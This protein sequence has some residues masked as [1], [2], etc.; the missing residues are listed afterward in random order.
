MVHRIVVEDQSLRWY[1]RPP[2]I[3]D[4]SIEFVR[5][6]F[7]LPE[8]WDPL[9]LVAQF[10]QADTYNMLLDGDTCF[11]P[12]E[13]TPGLCKL[14]LFGYAE[15]KPLRATSIPLVFQIEESGFVS[16]A[17]TPIPPTPDLYAQLIDHFA[18]TAGSGGKSNVFIAEYGVTS[19]EEIQTAID[20]GKQ[21]Y[22][23]FSSIYYPYSNAMPDMWF[24]FSVCYRA[25]LQ[26]VTCT[27]DGKWTFNTIGAVSESDVKAEIK[28][29]YL[30][31]AIPTVK[32]VMD[33]A[34]PKGDYLLTPIGAIPGQMLAVKTVD[35]NGKPTEWETVT[36]KSIDESQ[37]VKASTLFESSGSD[38]TVLLPEVSI[39]IPDEGFVIREKILEISA[40]EE[41][42]ITWNGVEYD[43]VVQHLQEGDLSMLYF[44]GNVDALMG[45][46]D[47][48]EPFII[49]YVPDEYAETVGYS[50]GIISLYGESDVTLSVS[51]K[52]SK[53]IKAKYLPDIPGSGGNLELD[54]TLTQ[55]GKAADAKAVGDAISELS[56]GN[57]D[58]T[59]IVKSV[60]GVEPD[61]NGNV[62]L[63]GNCL[64]VD[65]D[66][67]T[68]KASHSYSEIMTAINNGSIV[69]M[70]YGGG[71]CRLDSYDD[72]AVYF[73]DL[74]P[75]DGVWQFTLKVLDDKSVI[76]NQQH[77]NYGKVKMVNGRMPDSDGDVKL[78]TGAT[79]WD[80]LPGRPF[81]VART[82]YNENTLKVE[83]DGYGYFGIGVT[84]FSPVTIDETYTFIVNGAKY[85]AVALDDVS[86]GSINFDFN[87]YEG[88][89]LNSVYVE[90]Y[91]GEYGEIVSG[92]NAGIVFRESGTYTVKVIKEGPTTLDEKFI[93]DTIARVKDIP[94]DFVT[95]WNDLTDK[96][97]GENAEVILEETPITFTEDNSYE[98]QFPY[99]KPFVH[100]EI[101]AIVVNGVTYELPGLI[102]HDMGDFM[103]D[104]WESD[105][106]VRVWQN[107]IYD[108]VNLVGFEYTAISVDWGTSETMTV[109]VYK[110]G[111]VKTLDE[112]FLPYK[113]ETWTF[114]M[115]DGSTMTKRV[116]VK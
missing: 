36:P 42:T 89:P 95:S 25:R 58:L 32:A 26:T 60:N 12:K 69:V 34:Q 45:T 18:S 108:H 67:S 47:S 112:K 96:P 85:E 100:G 114:E 31:S 110:K 98:Y 3:A 13:L 104:T 23:L 33:Y 40:D 20:D 55:E 62:E 71:H 46:G 82:I 115:A 76:I 65:Y 78:P 30:S 49:A 29:G 107:P 8:D 53:K 80:D 7:H 9:V 87:S 54:T 101:Y 41:Y 92:G 16:S 28:D 66:N 86:M 50:A 15:G 105:C 17:E 38:S 116:V 6:Q 88:C 37:F 10:T 74:H 68:K 51:T 94:K 57:V 2:K 4:D 1:G 111:E 103:I 27:K 39:S 113:T 97:F 56:G 63:M 75:N 14:S 77:Y 19:Y 64:V 5:F 99:T 61:E 102:D 93:P 59:G 70:K 83:D 52:V 44:L 79:S 24:D 48:G 43:C 35:S 72:K 73:V 21:V 90:A 84:D 22:A 106:P 91:Y 81:D 11:L 109:A